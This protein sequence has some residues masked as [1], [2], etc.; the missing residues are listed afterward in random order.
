MADELDEGLPHGLP[1]GRM[2]C[3]DVRD[4]EQREQQPDPHDFQGL[5]HHVFAPEAWKT[6]VPNRGQQ[7][8]HVRVR[9]K[10]KFENQN[11]QFCIFNGKSDVKY[12]YFPRYND[13]NNIF[14][15]EIILLACV[16]TWR[17]YSPGVHAACA[18]CILTNPINFKTD[19][20]ENESAYIISY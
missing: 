16:A 2:W 15:C 13:K 10:L 5:Q 14:L 6:L 20:T 12:K 11:T 4:R 1:D 3:D 9:N 18:G 17:L 19:Q 7:L 8:L